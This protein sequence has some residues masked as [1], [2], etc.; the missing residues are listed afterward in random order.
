MS[1][2]KCFGVDLAWSRLDFPSLCHERFSIVGLFWLL[3][4]GDLNKAFEFLADS[5]YPVHQFFL[6]MEKK[7]FF[8]FG[9]DEQF[10]FLKMW[11]YF[12]FLK[13]MK[14]FPDI[15]L[16]LQPW[17]SWCI[18]PI[19]CSQFGL[20]FKSYNQNIFFLSVMLMSQLGKC[21]KAIIYLHRHHQRC[22]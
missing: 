15:R 5:W 12:R 9:W 3:D 17:T 10:S 11:N 19:V 13:K 18:A 21:K 16:W 4:N 22:L 1:L 14:S 6:E 20:L 8:S 2:V 7:L